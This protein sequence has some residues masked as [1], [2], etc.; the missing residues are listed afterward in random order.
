MYKDP[1]KQEAYTRLKVIRQRCNRKG[2]IHYRYYGGKGVRCMLSVE[3]FFDFYATKPNGSWT[4]GRIDH[5]KDYTLDNIEWQT[6]QD[7]VK[8]RNKRHGL[9]KNR[10]S[11]KV[12]V[13]TDGITTI[14]NS[15]QEAAKF[16][17]ISKS[18][19][20]MYL[21]GNYKKP[22]SYCIRRLN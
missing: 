6:M 1:W 2:H 12:E 19:V 20:V 10:S 4:V 16:L 3:E 7:Q 22:K 13:V 18:E 8:E 17:D 5:S 21:K 14:F 15:Q 9:P 11:K